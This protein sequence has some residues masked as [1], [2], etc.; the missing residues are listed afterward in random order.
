[1]IVGALSAGNPLRVQTANI[2]RQH[3]QVKK[4]LVQEVKDW[5]MALLVF[6]DI[7]YSFLQEQTLFKIYDID[8]LYFILF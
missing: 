6:L 1:L 5:G 4:K 7:P 8:V 2:R 3:V